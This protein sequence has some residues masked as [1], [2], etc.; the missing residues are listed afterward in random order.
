MTKILLVEDMEI[1][2]KAA[3]VQLKDHDLTIVGDFVSFQREWEKGGWDVVLTDLH[4]PVDVTNDS[5]RG[6]GAIPHNQPQPIGAIV[7]L[8]AQHAHVQVK[9]VSKHGGTLNYPLEDI[10]VTINYKTDDEYMDITVNP[11]TLEPEPE[12]RRLL[13]FKR[14]IYVKNWIG[15][16]K[17][18]LAK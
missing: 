12:N 11:E 13:E 18:A 6:N 14:Q 17:L 7:V 2:Q 16:L 15:G 1:N 10:G 5:T 3:R 9:M 4:F 8:M